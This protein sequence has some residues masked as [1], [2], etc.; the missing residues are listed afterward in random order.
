MK[1]FTLKTLAEMTNSLLVGNEKHEISGVNS[2]EAASNNEASFLANSRYEEA[3]KKSN[4]G[5]ICVNHSSILFKEK[6]FLISDDP[7]RT[8]QA[9]AELILSA[10]FE[11]GFENI[12]P[13]AVIHPT[14]K[15][16]KDVKLGP[17][18]V[19]D[20]NAVIE[21]NTRILPHTYIGPNVKIGSFC[22]IYSNVTI[23]ESS[24]IGNRV[25]IQPGA[26]IG[27]CGFGFVSD[28]EGKHQ[29]LQQ[30]GFVVIED[31][32]EI[33][34]NTTIDRARFNHTI[35]KKGSKIDNL[36]QIAHNVEIGEN[37]LIAAQSGI[38][39]SSKTGKNVVLGGQVGVAGHLK[40]ADNVMVG[41]QSGISKNLSSGKYR[42][43]P[44]APISEWNR[45]SVL[46]RNLYSYV[47]KIK[48]IEEKLEKV[49]N[50][51]I[52]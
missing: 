37:N 1:L 21:N 2:L 36:V 32:V 35:I 15:I 47:E 38:S 33:G 3:M 23:R 25:I 28:S 46:C 39:G 11:S 31:D 12:H 24:K 13:T 50:E 40:L 44:A 51:K 29:K 49:E 42:G 26:V 10:D 19:I 22:T 34:A 30:L 17:F 48:K 45:E 27:S 8:F 6:N 18:V 20:K 41:A 5:V 9:I 4:A 16:G 43:T 52:N 7:S 14:A